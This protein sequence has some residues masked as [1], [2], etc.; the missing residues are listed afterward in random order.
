MATIEY[1]AGVFVFVSVFVFAFVVFVLANGRA[2]KVTLHCV[3]RYR[4]YKMET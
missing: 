1:V 3:V 2:K 4:T